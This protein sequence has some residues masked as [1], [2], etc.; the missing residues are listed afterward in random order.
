MLGMAKCCGETD[1]DVVCPFRTSC[2]RYTAPRNH[3]GETYIV[4]T[5]KTKKCKDYIEKVICQTKDC[6]NMQSKS[7]LITLCDECWNKLHPP[8][9]R[10]KKDN[11]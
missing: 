9:A 11:N 1:K 3:C 7:G 8:Y 6:D 10:R 4:P 5:W 2:Y